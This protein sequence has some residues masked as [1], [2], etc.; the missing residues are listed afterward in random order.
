MKYSQWLVPNS[1]WDF[2]LAQTNKSFQQLKRIESSV[3][4]GESRR[5]YIVICQK[6]SKFNNLVSIWWNAT[7]VN[8]DLYAISE[9]WSTC[10]TRKTR[11]MQTISHLHERMENRTIQASNCMKR[12]I[13][14][15]IARVIVSLPINSKKSV[16]L[17]KTTTLEIRQWKTGSKHSHSG[18]SLVLILTLYNEKWHS[19]YSPHD[20][21]H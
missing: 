1:N 5:L 7:V 15:P 19:P 14:A 20:I 9:E 4:N 13:Y 21:S 11:W 18:T 12:K 16:T 6:G 10:R 8:T 2:H 3:N 17:S